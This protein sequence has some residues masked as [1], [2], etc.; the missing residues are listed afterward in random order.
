MQENYKKRK[1][2]F[3]SFKL[4]K[5]ACPVP[6][7]PRLHDKKCS[8]REGKLHS[9]GVWRED[10]F[11]L[12]ATFFL[13]PVYSAQRT[14]FKTGSGSGVFARGSGRGPGSSNNAL[15]PDLHQDSPYFDSSA[16]RN[17]TALLGKAAYL[18]CRVKGLGNKTVSAVK[19]SRKSI[20]DPHCDSAE[21]WEF[22]GDFLAF[23]PPF[24]Y[25]IFYEI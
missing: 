25:F 18:N 4:G 8:T 20:Y 21:C 15:E 22:I 3:T 17:V 2:T 10:I 11:R 13:L 6:Q 9:W 19:P 14:G 7:I 1:R 12:T 5:I 16:S 24:L 23:F